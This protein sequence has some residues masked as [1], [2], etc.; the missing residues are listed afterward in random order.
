MIYGIKP[1]GR[2]RKY[3][4]VLLNNKSKEGTYYKRPFLMMWPGTS[5][6]NSLYRRFVFN[7]NIRKIAKVY[8]GNSYFNGAL[9]TLLGR[10]NT[11]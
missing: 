11:I 8:F 1:A 4:S 2:R 9:T 3:S 5:F 6:G 7:I 10:R